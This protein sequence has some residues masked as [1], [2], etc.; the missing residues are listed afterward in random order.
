MRSYEERVEAWKR[1][2]EQDRYLRD[3]QISEMDRRTNE[4]YGELNNLNFK[5]S[6]MIN[7]TD[8]WTV[9]SLVEEINDIESAQIQKK[10]NLGYNPNVKV[11]IRQ[12]DGSE[13][14]H[15]FIVDRSYNEL[16]FVVEL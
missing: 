14:K 8:K 2:V 7:I 3:W 5:Y 12:P 13:T 15:D 11:I 9:E 6:N 10:H 4:F 1:H 16:Q